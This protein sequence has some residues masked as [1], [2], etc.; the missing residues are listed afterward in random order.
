M[1]SYQQELLKS[2]ICIIN[3]AIQSGTIL[4]RWI[5]AINI[6]IPKKNGSHKVTDYR[7]IHIYEYDM[8]A[9]L[10]LK[11]KE[12][13]NNQKNKMSFVPVKLVTENRD[14]CNFQSTL[15]SLN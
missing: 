11:W 5:N 10:P 3:F 1:E 2:T 8:N 4:V 14:L 15:R 6:M 7:N 13:L 12:A 9:T